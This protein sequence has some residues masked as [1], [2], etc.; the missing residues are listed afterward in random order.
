MHSKSQQDWNK[1]RGCGFNSQHLT[2]KYVSNVAP[3][4]LKCTKKL[5]VCSVVSGLYVFN[6]KSL[7]WVESVVQLTYSSESHTFDPILI[8]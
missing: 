6:S 3:P 7:F 4:P 1:N 2:F 5:G 8:K